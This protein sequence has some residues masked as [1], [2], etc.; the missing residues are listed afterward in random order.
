M[1]GHFLPFLVTHT[2]STP[3]TPPK[4]SVEYSSGDIFLKICFGVD[5]GTKK[6]LH[7]GL[8]SNLYF[9]SYGWSIVAFLVTHTPPT[10]PTPPTYFVEYS[11]GDIFLT[12]CFD[13]GTGTK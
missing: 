4:Y 8:L 6:S 11:Y 5:M 1:G 10:S 7:I 9:F 2:P 12:I 3:Q 13:V